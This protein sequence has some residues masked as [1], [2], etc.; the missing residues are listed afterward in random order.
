[1]IR[2]EQDYTLR[3]PVERSGFERDTWCDRCQEADLGLVEP[4]E[5]EEDGRVFIEGKCRCCGG[6]VVSEII[7]KNV[8]E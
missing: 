2:K 5:Y 7:I 8:S 3:S 6:R 4:H 1:M